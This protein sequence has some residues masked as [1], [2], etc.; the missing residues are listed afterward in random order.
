M[1]QHFHSRE[2]DRDFDRIWF[3][4]LPGYETAPAASTPSVPLGAGATKPRAGTRRSPISRPSADGLDGTQVS[5]AG[6]V[7]K[8]NDGI[9]G[10]NWIHLQD[11]TGSPAS[12]TNDVLVTTDGTAK[13]G[14]DVVA[15]GTVRTKQDFGSGYSY[16]FMLA[17][18]RSATASARA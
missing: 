14:D 16:K 2:L 1:V 17:P 8:E 4:M 12:G 13:V 18:C 6:H 15:T 11:G 10:R 9:M 5:V 3:G 7:V